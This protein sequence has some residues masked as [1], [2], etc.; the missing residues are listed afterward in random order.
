MRMDERW[1]SALAAIFS[2]ALKCFVTGEHIRS[3]AFLDVEIGKTAHQPRNASARRLYFDG[4]GDRVAVVFDQVEHRQ[5]KIAGRVERF[6]KLAF[7]R[8]AVARGNVNDLIFFK[9]R[10]AVLDLGNE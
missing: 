3:V 6:P 1:A 4:D 5:L 2:G 9:V 10:G 7:A 8:R